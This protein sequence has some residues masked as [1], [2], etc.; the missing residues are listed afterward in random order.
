ME[1]RLLRS[2]KELLN[3]TQAPKAEV[4]GRTRDQSGQVGLQGH[5]ESVKKF[6]EFH[7]WALCEKKEIQRDRTGNVQS[8]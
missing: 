7:F 8:S 2:G 4:G 5:G 6:F 3:N 1:S